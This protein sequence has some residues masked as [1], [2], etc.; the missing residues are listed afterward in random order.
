VAWERIVP[1]ESCFIKVWEPGTGV[2]VLPLPSPPSPWQLDDNCIRLETAFSPNGRYIAGFIGVKDPAA[3]YSTLT[4]R[5]DFLQ[6][7]WT[8]FPRDCLASAVA[9]DGS[10]LGVREQTGQP[11]R[12]Y[13]PSASEIELLGQEAFFGVRYFTSDL[14]DEAWLS[15]SWASNLALARLHRWTRGGGLQPFLREA[16]ALGASFQE[17]SLLVYYSVHGPPLYLWRKDWG[18]V[19]LS[20]LYRPL[21]PPDH[22]WHGFEQ[23]QQPST[24]V[25]PFISANGRYVLLV[26]TDGV[27]SPASVVLLDRGP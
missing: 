21:L 5:Y 12:R 8:L 11:C 17:G 19:S 4:A 2:R 15:N 3:N 26:T 9:N 7:T 13:G 22:F 27:G 14:G 24:P 20:A 16:R 18:L 1:Y 6:G 23:V 25:G 10:I